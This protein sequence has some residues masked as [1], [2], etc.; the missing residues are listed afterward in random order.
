[1]PQL[2]KDPAQGTALTPAPDFELSRLAPSRPA[3]PLW[4]RLAD[5]P[6]DDPRDARPLSARLSQNTGWR[7]AHTQ[8]VLTE[9]RRFLYL[10]VRLQGRVCPSEAVDEAWHAHLL[11]SSRYFGDFCPRVLGYTLHH[12][13]SRGGA[14]EGARHAS[15]YRATLLAYQHVFGEA[16]PADI[17]PAP[18]ARFK[19]RTRHLNSRTHWAVPK[20]AEWLS[21][22]RTSAARAWAIALSLPAL[23]VLGCTQGRVTI[24][25]GTSGPDFLKL[26]LL[27]LIALAAFGF[28]RAARGRPAAVDVVRTTGLQAVDH[29]YVAGGTQ[30]AVQTALASLLQRGAISVS[31]EAASPGSA[32]RTHAPPPAGAP[33]LEHAVFDALRRGFAPDKLA[34][35]VQPAL[36]ALHEQLHA[37]GLLTSPRRD[38]RLRD[39]VDRAHHL[40]WAGLLVWGVLRILHGTQRGLPVVLLV[41]LTVVGGLLLAFFRANLPH[42]RTRE[43]RDLVRRATLALR[44]R[45][46]LGLADPLMPMALALIGASAL[47]LEMQA[48]R[49]AIAPMNRSDGSGSS[50]CGGSSDGGGDGGGG[51]G[52]CG[53]GD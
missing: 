47:G 4:Q 31:D 48:F 28:W 38:E 18:E 1:M 51:C 13:P 5:H 42:R 30:R 11:D 8:R 21:A 19:E 12:V 41:I 29:A 52:G 25:P 16:P 2:Q 40:L 45:S 35:Q 15:R 36:D 14:E 49:E 44:R 3:H 17:W 50:G 7:A 46:N 24:Q 23:L 34:A 33:P 39:P 53:G 22:S 26:Y 43:G 9:Y 37:R 6:L 20:P 27:A 10:A 32:W